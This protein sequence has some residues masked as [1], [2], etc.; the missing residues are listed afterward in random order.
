VEAHS[1]RPILTLKGLVASSPVMRDKVFALEEAMKKDEGIQL[2]ELPVVHHFSQGVYGR[3]MVIPKGT[4]VTGKIHK[5]EQ[6]NILLCGELSVLTEDGVKRIK[7]PFVVVSPP[8]TKRVAYA[9]EDSRWLTVHG[10]EKQ[11]VE[12]IEKEFIAQTEREYI[13][14]VEQLKLGERKCLGQR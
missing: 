3:E 6:L 4:I 13:E 10:T 7:P 9:H 5:F 12:E 1:L 2:Y 11:D 14:F 8:G